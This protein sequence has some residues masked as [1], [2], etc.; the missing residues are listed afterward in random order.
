MRHDRVLRRAL[1]ADRRIV[2]QDVEA[3]EMGKRLLRHGVDRRR[4][5]HIG[6]DG[7]GVAARARSRERRFRLLA[8]CPRID[9]DP[10]TAR[11]ELKRDRP[12]D[13]AARPGHQRDLARSSVPLISPAMATSTS[14]ASK[15]VCAHWAARSARLLPAAMQRIGG[16]FLDFCLRQRL[17]N[18]AAQMRLA[19]FQDLPV[20][21]RHPDMPRIAAG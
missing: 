10:G 20:I 11:R 3:A 15:S 8:I 16:I 19:F 13:I 18:A 7:D 12:P 1:I 17:G 5:G 4:V 9:D 2:D 6:K 21:E 14:S